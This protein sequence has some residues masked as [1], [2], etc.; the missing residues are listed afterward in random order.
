M[1]GHGT[2]GSASVGPRWL[3]GAAPRTASSG[4]ESIDRAT[5]GWEDALRSAIGSDRVQTRLIDRLALA[6]DASHYLQVPE[7]V[8][9]AGSPAE[10]ASALMACRAAGRSVTFRSG[11]TSLSGQA[12]TDGLL[13]ETRR[14]FTAIEV[15]DGGERVRVQPGATVRSVNT[16]LAAYGRKLGPDPASEIACTVGGIVANNSSGMECGTQHNTYRTL[17]SLVVVLASGTVIDTG[18]PDADARLREAEPDIWNGLLRLRNRVR[19]S[20]ESRRVIA[21]QYAIKNTMGYGLNSFVDFDR[22][23]DIL[24]HLLVGSEGTLGFVAEATLRTVPIPRQVATTLLVFEDLQRA[25]GAI[26]PLVATGVRSLELMDARSLRVSQQLPGADPVLASLQVGAHTA[27][28]AD[29]AADDQARLGELVNAVER[30]LLD[31]VPAVATSGFVRDAARRGR[32]WQARKGLYTA[33]AGARPSGSTAILEDIA[34]PAPALSDATASLTGLLTAHGYD[35]AVIF[36]HAKD[37]NLHF[38]IS[39]DLDDPAQLRSYEEFTD[40]LVDLVLAHDG[41]LKAEHGT[42]RIMAPFVRRQFGD[43]LYEVMVE[44][45]RLLDPTRTLNP[46]TVLTEDPAAHIRHIKSL[47][48]V[49]AAVDAC[50]ECGYCETVCPS[51]GVTTTPRQR[52]VLMREMSHRPEHERREL[53]ADFEYA[54]IQTCAADSL[55]RTVCPVGI[56]TG[57]VM[58]RKRAET[59]GAAAQA[60][61]RSAARHFA[62]L[63]I[64]LRRGI[65]AASRVAPAARGAATRRARRMVGTEWLPDLGGQVPRPGDRRRARIP[66]APA[67]AVYLPACVNSMFGAEADQISLSDAVFRLA[68]LAGVELLVPPG[69]AGMCCA[70]PWE[71]KGLTRGADEMR[72]ITSEALGA[73]TDGGRLPVVIDASSCAH[74]LGSVDRSYGPRTT[75]DVVTFVRERILP[76]LDVPQPLARIA[77]HPTCSSVH[78]GN[79][80]DLLAVAG[81]CADRVEIPPSWGCCGYAGDRGMLHPELTAAATQA[82]A[83]EVLAG[84]Y[85]A[86]VSHNRTCEM[87]MSQATGRP[88]QHVVQLLATRARARD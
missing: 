9:Y 8:A 19:A 15:L 35:E 30:R 70:T 17:Q 14:Y 13:L 47:P 67:D 28:L 53:E 22:P 87:A 52:I 12:Q 10:V 44:V 73:A 54:G 37:G 56:D 79:L 5:Q 24:A 3:P 71:S 31:E 42:G 29:V 65:A 63:T 46:G 66:A 61:G 1:S 85:D 40:E 74:G 41:T 21:S 88:Y 2:G 4:A 76:H 34:V 59:L 72:R 6:H 78:L 84:N 11:G 16:R 49:D 68:A 36:G 81:A 77:L 20:D 69:I 26:E 83:A 86:F 51:R 82:Q 43:E 50:V 75:I 32:L 25:T 64:G 48:V 57:T 18:A 23:V 33:V 55:C 27:L 62:G 60:T 39:P 80:D 38:L 45:K 58:K 7:V